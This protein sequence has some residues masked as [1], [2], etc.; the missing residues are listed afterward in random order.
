MNTQTRPSSAPTAQQAIPLIYR[1]KNASTRANRTVVVDSACS[2]LHAGAAQEDV[3]HHADQGSTSSTRWAAVS[4]IRRAPQL[5]QIARPLHEKARACS[6]W[7]RPQKRRTKQLARTQRAMSPFYAVTEGLGNGAR[8]FVSS[9]NFGLPR[10]ADG[11]AHT[12]PSN[13][14]ALVCGRSTSTPCEMIGGC[15]CI[16]RWHRPCYSRWWLGS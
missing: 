5:G 14:P 8:L 12:Q 9:S 3:G 7:H 16:G 4:T 11:Q 6:H 13:D 10:C 1:R 2:S 15:A